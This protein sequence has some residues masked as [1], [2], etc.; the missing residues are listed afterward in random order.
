[1]QIQNLENILI[2]HDDLDIQFGKVKIKKG[3]SAEGHRGIKSIIEQLET[4][5]FKRMKIGVGRILEKKIQL[6]HMFQVNLMKKFIERVLAFT[7]LQERQKY[8]IDDGMSFGA[9]FTLNP[10]LY[11]ILGYI[12][13]SN[14]TRKKFIYTKTQKIQENNYLEIFMQEELP[15]QDEIQLLQ[16]FFQQIIVCYDIIFVELTKD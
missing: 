4:N 8:K 9:D 5:E 1:M 11:E 6:K 13:V 7:K 12:R 14:N 2:V 3:G 16:L 10:E 15:N